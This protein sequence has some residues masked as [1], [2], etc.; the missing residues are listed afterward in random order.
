MWSGEERRS[1]RV[2]PIG[3]LHGASNS[4]SG[5]FVLQAPVGS[6]GSQEALVPIVQRALHRGCVQRTLLK[7]LLDAFWE[8]RPADGRVF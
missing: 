5:R 1:Q 8:K 3:R 6:S 4:S 7:R 2:A